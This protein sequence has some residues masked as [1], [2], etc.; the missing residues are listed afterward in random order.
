M[1]V[2]KASA[3]GLFTTRQQIG[4]TLNNGTLNNGIPQPSPSSQPTR[5]A[6]DN[7]TELTSITLRKEKL[8]TRK[9]W[10]PFDMI[11]FQRMFAMYLE[12]M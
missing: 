2:A 9:V 7:I 8:F 4:N 1:L 12:Q 6:E 3:A 10:A 5:F 11:P